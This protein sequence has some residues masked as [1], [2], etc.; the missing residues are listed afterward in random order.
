MSKAIGLRGN[1][2]S[3]GRE[4]EVS[5]KKPTDPS[6]MGDLQTGA[7]NPCQESVGRE[8]PRIL[9]RGRVKIECAPGES[10]RQTEVRGGY[11]NY[12]KR[13]P[14]ARKPL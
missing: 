12:N 5:R 9:R 4:I 2:R 10:E 1:G 8:M 3:R 13:G 14:A 6:Q 7:W 11:G